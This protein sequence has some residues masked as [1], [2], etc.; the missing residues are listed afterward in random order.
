MGATP[1]SIDLKSMVLMPKQSAALPTRWRADAIVPRLSPFPKSRPAPP[2]GAWRSLLAGAKGYRF[3]VFAQVQ[4]GRENFKACLAL[5][6]SGIWQVLVR[7]ESHGGHPGLHVHD[8]CGTPQPP[9][10]GKSFDAP[11]RRPR[12][13]SH[14]RRIYPLTRA[15]FWRLALDC[16]RVVPSGSDQEELL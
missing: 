2:N 9:I 8:W 15:T 6:Q 7:L 10:G 11:N 4:E 13:R 12:S 5:E 3:M 16:F 1:T 14:H